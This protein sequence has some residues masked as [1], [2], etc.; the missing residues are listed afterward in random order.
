[1]KRQ[2]RIFLDDILRNVIQAVSRWREVGRQIG[3]SP[4]EL[5]AFEPA[6]NTQTTIP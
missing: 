6:F 1:M 5:D 4:N 2:I 3:M